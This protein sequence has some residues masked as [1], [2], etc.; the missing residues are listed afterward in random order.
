MIVIAGALVIVGAGSAHH[1][2]AAK[3]SDGPLQACLQLHDMELHPSANSVPA[4][5]KRQSRPRRRAPGSAT[6]SI[7]GF[8]TWRPEPRSLRGR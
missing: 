5:V 3:A 2:A 8:R 4:S 6:T 7:S 1:V